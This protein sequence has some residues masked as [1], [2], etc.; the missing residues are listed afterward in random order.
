MKCYS[1]YPKLSAN[2]RMLHVIDKQDQD[3]S[4]PRKL[5]I[6]VFLVTILASAIT[7]LASTQAE[8][9]CDRWNNQNLPECRR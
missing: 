3:K 5:V 8:D 4:M 6:S 7:P 1:L 9:F 2:D